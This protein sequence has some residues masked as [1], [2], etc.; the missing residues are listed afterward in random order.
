LYHKR[1]GDVRWFKEAEHAVKWDEETRKSYGIPQSALVGSNKDGSFREGVALSGIS[2][3]LA[4]RHL[5]LGALWES[6]KVYGLF[7]KNPD[8]TPIDFLIAILNSQTYTDIANALNHTVSLQVRDVKALPMFSYTR[9]EVE[10]LTELGGK[11]VTWSKSG[12]VGE[13][14]EQANIDTIVKRAANRP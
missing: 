1:G 10:E 14:P 3:K 2:Q 5:S 8:E 6:N 4:A 12:G 7:P 11:A 13:F 9:D